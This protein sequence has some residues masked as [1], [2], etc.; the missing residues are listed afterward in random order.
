MD[1]LQELAIRKNKLF[2]LSGKGV[3]GMTTNY[4]G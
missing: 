1:A 2:Q 3:P 4:T